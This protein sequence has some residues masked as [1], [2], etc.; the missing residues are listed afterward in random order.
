MYVCEGRGN[1][2]VCV[3]WGVGV[4]VCEGRGNV[5]VCWGA[6]GCMY[7]GDVCMWGGGEM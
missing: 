6:G 4:Y 5:C 2:F 7:E 1:V 3:C